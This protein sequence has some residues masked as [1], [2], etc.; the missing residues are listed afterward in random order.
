MAYIGSF[1]NQHSPRFL[2][3]GNILVFD[4]YAF[5][6]NGSKFGHTAIKEIN[7]EKKEIVSIFNG[8]PDFNFQ[9]QRRGR[10]QV[11]KDEIFVI[12]GDQSV[13]FKLICTNRNERKFLNECKFKKIFQ[14]NDGQPE[15]Y[16]TKNS[17]FMS[18]IY[19]KKIIN[20]SCMSKFTIY[21][22]F[23]YFNFSFAYAYLGLGPLIP[24]I[25]SAIVYIFI[26]IVA[27]LSFLWWP[28]KKLIKFLKKRNKKKK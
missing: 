14:F 23:I 25:G 15:T 26:F 8:G 1:E 21:F 6:E 2:E 9:S 17:I 10:I 28:F 4:N 5:D 22:I 3:N 24:F 11:V 18:D 13:F 16:P 12:S 19:I 27:I 20:L 7:L